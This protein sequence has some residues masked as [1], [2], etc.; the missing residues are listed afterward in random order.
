MG[1]LVHDREFDP[2]YGQVVTLSERVRRLTAAN[3]GPF[4]FHG[5][6]TFLIGR[7]EVAVI[8]P[9]PEDPAHVAAIVAAAGADR[10]RHIVV[11]HTHRDHSPGAALLKA[12]TG[13]EILA[14]G[15]HREA[16]RTIPIAG[17]GLEAGGDREFRPDRTI[18]HGDRIK[19]RDYVLEA[20]ATPGH[21]PNHLAFALDGE[22][23]IFSGDHVMGWSTTVVAPPDGAM[24]EYMESLD[25]LLARPEALYHPAHGGPIGDAHTYV[26]A[27]AGHRRARAAAVLDRLAD[28]PAT[29]PELVTMIYR[30]L[31]PG[32][33][34]AAR[35]SLLAHVEELVASGAVG[36]DDPVLSQESRYRLAG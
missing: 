13:A 15:P 21:T 1:T 4:T 29:I 33:V 30:G 14:E 7:E 18:G 16:E 35:L 2:R 9:G 10:I 32:L 26:A 34:P 36:S 12:L 25:R 24:R 6:N 20:I 28:G 17:R 8:D 23:A 31:E 19:G 5:T 27:L 3:P 11:T 22:G